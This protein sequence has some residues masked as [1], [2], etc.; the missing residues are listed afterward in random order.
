M[1]ILTAFVREQSVRWYISSQRW[2]TDDFLHTSYLDP[3]QPEI[4]ISVDVQA[5]LTVI[6]RRK[7]VDKERGKIIDLS[8]SYLKGAMLFD[9][10]LNNSNLAGINLAGATIYDSNLDSA[11]LIKAILIGANFGYTKLE[12]ARLDE[13]DL[14][15]ANL[16][17]SIELTWEQISVATIDEST[18]LPPELEERRKAEQAEQSKKAAAP[19]Q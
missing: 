9:A 14:T 2:V 11:V 5:A 13:A 6:G 7:W 12:R 16:S 4:N 3:V 15:G 19:N 10:N 18:K 8:E 1:E 17:T